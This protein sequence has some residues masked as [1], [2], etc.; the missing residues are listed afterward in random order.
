MGSLSSLPGDLSRIWSRLPRGQKLTLAV[1]AGGAIALLALFASW[2]RTPDYVPLYTRLEA[3]DGAA[4][5]DSLQSQGVPYEVADGGS[6]VRVPSS[7]VASARLALAAEGLPAGGGVGFEVFDGQS[8]G[9]TDFVQRVNLRRSLEGELTRTINQLEAVQGSRVHIAIPDDQLF[10]DLQNDATASVVLDI[11]AGRSLAASQVRGIAHLVAQAVEGLD[12]AHITI[13]NSKGDILYDGTDALGTAGGTQLEMTQAFEDQMER[14]LGLFLRSV[15]GPN[16]SAVAVTAVL[17]FTR[18]ETT[19]ETFTPIEN[20]Q[21]STQTVTE[22]F[23][24][25]GTLGDLAVPGAVANVPGLNAPET[26]TTDAGSSSAYQRTEAT[27]SNELNRTLETVANAP[28]QVQHLSISV[29]LDESITEAQATQLQ[30]AIRAAAGVDTERG[31][32]ITVVRVL[33]DTTE[34]EDAKAAI[35]AEAASN[36]MMNMVQLAVPVVAVLLAGGVFTFLIRKISAIRASAP[37][38]YMLAVDYPALGG[39][40]QSQEALVAQRMRELESQHRDQTSKQLATL[41]RTR[42]QAVAEVV[43]TWMREEG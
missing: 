29:L 2:S 8:L 17:D 37:T 3:A 26:D 28:G 14:D 5:V 38:G 32:A 13:L 23:S 11:R 7:Q 35:A 12:P 10:T 39:V 42:P 19:R 31:D 18:T 4:I 21:R 34:L 41:T 36:Q 30:D 40:G 1:L 43:Q 20:G 22:Q 9:V 16:K 24:G 25:D 33:F 27:T 15:L 6:T